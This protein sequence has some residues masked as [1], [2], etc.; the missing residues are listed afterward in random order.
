MQKRVVVFIFGVL[1]DNFLW[2]SVGWAVM[3]PKGRGGDGVVLPSGGTRSPA[4]RHFT[5]PSAFFFL[6]IRSPLSSHTRSNTPTRCITW[7]YDAWFVIVRTSGF[8]LR[9]E[10]DTFVFGMSVLILR[11]LITAKHLHPFAMFRV[12][13]QKSRQS[14]TSTW[15][16]GWSN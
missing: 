12:R 10:S 11:G 9:A 13:R 14:S 16:T 15:R 3:T 6:L 2:V 4:P 8:S 1:F 5:T 7:V